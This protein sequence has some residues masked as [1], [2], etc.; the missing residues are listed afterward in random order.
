MSSP[1]L[2]GGVA[3][4]TG[5]TGQLGAAYV[6]A[7]RS[8]GATVVAVDK[9]PSDGCVAIDV[10]D[11]AAVAAGFERIADEH[12]HIDFLVNNAGIGAY[13]PLEERTLDQ[14]MDVVGVNLVGTILCTRA[15]TSYMPDGGSVVNVGSIYGLVAPDPRIYGDSGRNSSEIYGGTKAGVIQMTKWFAVELAPRRIR[16]NALTPGGVF[17]NQTPFFVDAY[18]ARTPLGR[19]ADPEDLVGPLLF[20]LSE[21]ARYVTGH[22][23]VVDGGW[24]VW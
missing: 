16:V 17:A 14:I 20:L 8:A 18:E 12:G 4:V 24:S 7:L 9:D 13:T 19:M 23:L 21:G 6:K 2:E 15:A 10:S 1:T 5:A 3:V 11:P 22:N